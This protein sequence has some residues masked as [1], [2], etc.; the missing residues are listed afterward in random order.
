MYLSIDINEIKFVHKIDKRVPIICS[1]PGLAATL[2]DGIEGC[3]FQSPAMIT[4]E[5]FVFDMSCSLNV[6][7]KLSWSR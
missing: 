4:F 7:I 6:R 5:M 1:L 2:I 3:I